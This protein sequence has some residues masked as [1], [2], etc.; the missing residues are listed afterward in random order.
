MTDRQPPVTDADI[1]RELEY[2]LSQVK[3]DKLLELVAEKFEE[4]GGRKANRKKRWEWERLAETLR[5]LSGLAFTL[6]ND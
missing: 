5:G 4:I 1:K 3:P 6:W 2:W